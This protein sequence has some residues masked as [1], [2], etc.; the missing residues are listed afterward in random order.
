MAAGFALLLVSLGALGVI[1][2][3]EWS[4]RP[5]HPPTVNW[6][7]TPLALCAILYSYE[8]INLILPVESAMKEPE[9]F[10]PVFWSSMV[11]VACL[12]ATVAAAC[13]LAFGNVTNGSVTAFL[14]DAY[15]DDDTVTLFI[16]IANTAVSLSVLLTY[17]L[18]LFPAIELLGPMIEQ[19][20]YMSKL[21]CLFP[22]GSGGD[23]EDD[24]DGQDLA[25]FEPLP[26]LP[27]HE[28]YDE[29]LEESAAFI[30]DQQQQ[31]N[32]HASNYQS[33]ATSTTNLVTGIVNDSDK[34]G[35]VGGDETFSAVSSV[36]N[37]SLMQQRKTNVMP[38]DSV[39]MRLFLVFV[40]YL[41]AVV[42]PNVQA[43]ISLAGALAG[44]ST[45]L[46]IPP[47]LEL[48]W[49]EHLEHTIKSTKENRPPPPSPHLMRMVAQFHQQ[50][51][52]QHN[53]NTN[54]HLHAATNAIIKQWFS[55][56][57][58]VEQLKCYVLLGLGLVFML[59]GTCASLADI[60]KI[61]MG[62]K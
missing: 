62:K 27:E 39:Q 7:Q 6:L 4:D 43:L 21:L 11:V 41:V 40:T 48:A 17:P 29:D 31:S 51:K 9:K 61:Y 33:I 44:S 15:R 54:G 8:G 2:F 46:L 22:K 13:V 42:V 16:M 25:G 50:Q 35:L 45:A 59:I 32:D 3:E 56:R 20:K 36:T 26:P 38:G 10:A 57:Y 12:L 37:K 24:E 49:M 5:E 23:L 34:D 60:A 52:H 47:V 14:L 30:N 58:W 19:N 28:M 55:S 18:Q 53:T 1:V